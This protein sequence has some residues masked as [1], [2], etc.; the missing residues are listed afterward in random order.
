MERRKFIKSTAAAGVI[1]GFALNSRGAGISDRKKSSGGSYDLVGIKGG[2]PA[3]MFDRGIKELGGMGAFVKKGQTV[4]VKPNIGWARDPESGADTNPELVKRVI[5]HCF[6]AGAKSVHMFDHTCNSWRDCY[7]KSG[8]NAVAASTEA[9][10]VGGNHKNDYREVDIPQ[11]VKLKSAKIHKLILDSDVFIN[12]PVLK[13][14]GGAVMTCAMKNL[15]GIVWDR[16]FFHKNDLQQ[17]IADI[18]TVCKPNLNI[19][20]AYRV[21]K[22]GGPRG[23]DLKDVATMKYQLISTDIVAID[24]VASKV[25]DISTDRI[26]HIKNGEKL[27]LGSMALDKLKIKRINMSAA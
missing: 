24:T 4:V 13:N 14:H 22:K 27:G 11:G 5:E 1:G 3:E 17:C 25:I 9:K 7:E 8:M 26:S 12:V 10:L 19:V 18:V 23:R 21:M 16:R 15:M 20:D 6:K 2:N